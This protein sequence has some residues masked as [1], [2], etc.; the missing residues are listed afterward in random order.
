M[1]VLNIGDADYPSANY[2]G[3]ALQLKKKIYAGK[4]LI[5]EVIVGY[6]SF[7]LVERMDIDFADISENE[8][9][10]QINK[11]TD[12]M[13]DKNAFFTVGTILQISLIN[14]G[15]KTFFVGYQVTAIGNQRDAIYQN[16]PPDEMGFNFEALQSAITKSNDGYSLRIIKITNQ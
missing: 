13:P 15:V 6:I 10:E 5:D 14:S 2:E 9:I 4:F 3:W 1:C 12:K 11:R 8:A 7:V 16:Y